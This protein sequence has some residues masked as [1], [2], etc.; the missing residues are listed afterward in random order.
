LINSLEAL[1]SASSEKPS[2]YLAPKVEGSVCSE[3][4]DSLVQKRAESKGCSFEDEAEKEI[5][6][7]SDYARE[8]F[9]VK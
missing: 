5:E 8:A 7:T 9:A 3:C 1:L 4:V 6:L 2:T